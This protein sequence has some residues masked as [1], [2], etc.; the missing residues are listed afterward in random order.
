LV[1]FYHILTF[2][3]ETLEELAGEVQGT[4]NY[5]VCSPLHLAITVRNEQLTPIQPTSAGHRLAGKSIE[6]GSDQ[7]TTPV[8]APQNDNAV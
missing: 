4:A 8:M 5:D 3:L 7:P 2:L 1:N 6:N